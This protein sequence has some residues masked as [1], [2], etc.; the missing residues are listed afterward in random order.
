MA[1]L[2]GWLLIDAIVVVLL[3]RLLRRLVRLLIPALVVA[4]VVSLVIVA[5]SRTLPRSERPTW[6]AYVADA[7]VFMDVVPCRA[8]LDTILDNPSVVLI[9]NAVIL[10]EAAGRQDRNGSQERRLSRLAWGGARRL[11]DATQPPPGLADLL[12]AS[13]DEVDATVL[14]TAVR[15]GVPVLSTNAA[16]LRRQIDSQPARRAHFGAVRLVDPCITPLP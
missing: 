9:V 5:I 6:E 3:V 7:G 2:A 8:R 13:F 15:H 11:P 4:L 12:S 1:T 16:A 10:T 14:Q